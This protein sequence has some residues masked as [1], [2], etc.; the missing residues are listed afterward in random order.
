MNIL[1]TEDE[2]ILL[3]AQ[4]ESL[5][6][7][8]LPQRS[9]QPSNR[10]NLPALELFRRP[11]IGRPIANTC[12]YILDPH[13]QPTPIGVPG[14]L[15]VGGAGLARGYLNRPQITAEKFIANPFGNG[16]LYKTGDWARYRTDGTIEFLGRIDHQVKIRGFR[17]ELGEIEAVLSSHEWVQQCAVMAREDSPGKQ[18]LVAYVVGN[19]GLDISDLKAYL[20]QRLLDYMVP[21][22]FVALQALPLNANS[23]LDRGALPH[24]ENN[25]LIDNESVA[26]STPH[27]IALA[28][29]FAQVLALPV[30]RIGIHDSFFELGGHSLLATE[31]STQ[32]RR[33]LHVDM[34]LRQLFETPTIAGLA[35]WLAHQP[36][37]ADRARLIAPV[38]REQPL[39]LS[40]AQERIWF[41]DQFDPGNVAY[42]Q[43]A[44]V[45]LTG[46]VNVSVLHQSLQAIVER[47]EILRTTFPTEQGQPVQQI[48]AVGDIPLS[49]SDLRPFP[50]EQQQTEVQRLAVSIVNEPF[51]LTQGPLLHAH[52]LQLSAQE[53]VLLWSMHHIISDG[54]SMGVLVKELAAIYAA[55]ITATPTPLQ[56]LPIQYAD[57]AHWQRQWLTGEV[58]EHQLAYWRQKLGGNLPVLRLPTDYPAPAAP[59]FRGA[60]ATFQLST[61]LTSQIQALS[62]AAGSTLFMTLLA[63]FKALLYAYTG[64]YDLLVGTDIANRNQADLEKLI[65]FFVNL[66][67]LR[68]DLSGNPKFR[69]LLQRVRAVTLDAYEHQD[70]PFARLVQ[71]L[72]PA[73]AV[74]VARRGMTT[75][76]FQVLFVL[77]N[78]PSQQL[79]LPGVTLTPMDMPLSSVKFDLALFLHET[80]S[81]IK[82]VWNYSTDRFAAATIDRMAQ[83]FEGVLQ[84][85]VQQ[86]DITLESLAHRVVPQSLPT[87]SAP[88]R[89][90]FKRVAPQSVRRSSADLVTNYV[91]PCGVSTIQP[92]DESVDLA[93]W[94]QGQRAALHQQLH[95]QGALLFRGFSIPTAAA[96]E[97]VAQ[98]IC[99]ELFGDYGDLPRAGVSGKVYGSTP[100]PEDKAILFHNESSHLQQWPMKIW[101]CCLQVAQQGGATPI[102]D[103]RRVYQVLPVEVRDRLLNRQLMYVR[104]YIKGLDVS[105]QEFFQTTDRAVVEQRC[106]ATGMAWEWLEADG[107][108]TRQVRP[109]IVRHPRTGE[110]VVFNQLQLHHLSY[111][112]APTQA[113]LL[114][115][116]GEERLPRHVYYG[117]G[118]PIEPDVLEALQAA[119]TQVEQV[120]P[121]Q[122]GDI[123]MLDNM[124]MAHGRQTYKGSRKV[125]VAMAE[126][127]TQA[128]LEAK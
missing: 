94:V 41:I 75:P 33:V 71:A 98:A 24:P 87:S 19:D 57:F 81:G 91:L 39:P 5:G 51:D 123:L 30:E 8:P 21:S 3:N 63:G 70:L 42:N 72:Q 127:M 28:K 99:P 110:W 48:A 16:R 107:L 68:T 23:K 14:E 25:L 112:D 74:G 120:F 90:K 47:H 84:E 4:L 22:V 49:L 82:V 106:R 88:R 83:Q 64:Q 101:F 103:C 124:L 76:L 65:G 36:L 62:Q 11:P 6:Y 27:Q 86:P 111:L 40:F 52:L 15:H 113:S 32:M 116:F 115:L 10:N 108:Q 93:I 128:E 13:L 53:H 100:Y 54:W 45:R 114:S 97:Q 56:P 61:D 104:N 17:V 118:S 43:S 96:F 126:I 77:Q 89:K 59:S 2:R 46:K 121:W 67:V 35:L 66:L 69:D 44:A 20:K 26:P 29:L 55:G 73:T 58:L 31:V 34:P 125:A 92:H 109:A 18:R 37:T 38:S 78:L 60:T 7:K 95:Q 122:Q 79:D 9:S 119:Y 1:L 117:D 80:A 102:V 85:I 12:V 105:W 50:P